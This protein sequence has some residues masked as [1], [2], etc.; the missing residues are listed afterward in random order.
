MSFLVFSCVPCLIAMSHGEGACSEHRRAAVELTVRN[1]T[2]KRES[3]ADFLRSLGIA[4]AER[5][6]CVSVLLAVLTLQRNRAVRASR[7]T[8]RPSEWA[9]M[10]SELADFPGAPMRDE[11]DAAFVAFAE[12]LFGVKVLWSH[13]SESPEPTA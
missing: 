4:P 3:D 1:L 10:R 6:P 8:V 12:S 9:V 2:A 13:L 11:S 7:M 5:P